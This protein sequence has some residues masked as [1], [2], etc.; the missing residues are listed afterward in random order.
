M[1]EHH[2]RPL[3]ADAASGWASRRRP[4]AVDPPAKTLAAKADVAVVPAGF[5]PMTESEGYDRT[6]QLPP[7]RTI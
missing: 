2:G 5:D 6:F 1:L 4:T 3:A 7:G